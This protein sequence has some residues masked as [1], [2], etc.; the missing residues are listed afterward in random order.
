[1]IAS[2]R[3]HMRARKELHPTDLVREA[4]AAQVLN[5]MNRSKLGTSGAMRPTLSPASETD[6]DCVR[7]AFGDKQQTGLSVR[8]PVSRP[9]RVNRRRRGTCER[10]EWAMMPPDER[11]KWPC[12]EDGRHSMLRFMIVLVIGLAANVNSVT[13]ASTQSYPQRAVKFILPLAPPPEST[14]PPGCSAI[15]SRRAG[16]S[17]W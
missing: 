13:V 15:S 5:F 6:L 1:M 12:C 3:I 4:L 7:P 17:R 11:A 16:A 2:K 8:R 14:S 10:R 9:Y